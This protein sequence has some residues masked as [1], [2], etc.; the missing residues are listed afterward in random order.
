MTRTHHH[1]HRHRR[2]IATVVFTST[3]LGLIALALGDTNPGIA[4]AALISVA[5][6]ATVFHFVLP[7][8]DFFSAV[9][10]NSIG[11]YAC[12]YVFFIS[13]NF[14]S[15]GARA[16]EIGFVL[17][18]I[19]FLFGVLWRRRRIAA[20]VERSDEQMDK[21]IWHAAIWIPP[22]IAVGVASFVAPLREFPPADQALA[23]L[24]AMTII[25][26]TALLA[27]ADIA[28]FLLDTA[29]LFEDFFENAARLAKPAFAFFTCYSL[30]AIVFACLYTILDR[31]SA[32]PNFL[33]DGHGRRINLGEG[34]YLSVVTLSTVGFGDLT[35]HTPV[36]RIMVAGEIFSGV[37]LLLF[38]V[39]A[40]LTSG[41]K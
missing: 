14:G 10:A 33:L 2:L 36:A 15:A 29:V 6:L 11:I 38:G 17:P 1:H 28:A 16:Q 19:G 27:A 24:G 25:A 30:L 23:L 7:G 4:I 34:L 32:T 35:A 21:D 18:L 3:L 37:L 22:L 41:R 40:I 39:Q 13:E 26:L 20:A 5:A 31:Y 8:S 12:V 9:F